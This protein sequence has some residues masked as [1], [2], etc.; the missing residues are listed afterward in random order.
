MGDIYK[1]ILKGQEKELAIAYTNLERRIQQLHEA[2]GA[3]YTSLGS[4]SI[5]EKLM[6]LKANITNFIAT[7]SA[8]YMLPDKYFSDLK[9]L[10]NRLTYLA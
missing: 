8:T 5:S 9:I 3:K 10:N 6:N 1:G 2:F 7:S 4:A